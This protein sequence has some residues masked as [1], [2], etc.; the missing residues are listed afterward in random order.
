MNKNLQSLLLICAAVLLFGACQKDEPA[1]AVSIRATIADAYTP[2][3][4]GAKVVVDNTVMPSFV[5]GDKVWVNGAEFTASVSGSDF[6]LELTDGS[7]DSPYSAVYP[8]DFVTSVSGGFPVNLTLPAEQEYVEQNGKQVINAPMAAFGDGEPQLEFKNVCSLVRVR[9][10]NNLGMGEIT[11]SSITITASDANLSGSATISENEGGFTLLVTSG[12]KSVTLTG[13]TEVVKENKSSKDYYIYIPPV[14]GETL[15]ITVNGSDEYKSLAEWSQVSTNEVSIAKS[16]VGAVSQLLQDCESSYTM[17]FS[18]SADKQIYFSK[19]NLQYQPSTNTWR[20]AEKPWIYFVDN[21]SYGNCMTQNA[22]A[23]TDKWIDLFAWGTSGWSGGVN[24]SPYH[25]PYCRIVTGT[26][27]TTTGYGY[28]PTYNS[29]QQSLVGDYANSDWGV[30]NSIWNGSNLDAAGTWRTPTS[31]EWSY[32][33]NRTNRHTI[34]TVN[35][36]K[37]L[38]LLPDHWSKPAELAMTYAATGYTTNVYTEEQWT[39]LEKKGAI[40]LPITGKCINK[41]TSASS[42]YTLTSQTTIG[43]Y[44]STTYYS[45][46]SAKSF[47]FNN[48]GGGGAGSGDGTGYQIKCAR[49]AVRLVKDVQ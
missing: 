9:V 32:L 6:T 38:I 10:R 16:K 42:T 30:Y 1:S 33:Y 47:Y 44:W 22:V 40:F 13:L 12:E 31:S 39:L 2:N 41:I 15:T 26:G 35:S 25:L 14:S 28:G 43:Y 24:A 17:A 46:S 48:T 5:T 4:S 19:G 36:V 11:L 34:A 27:A 7:T 37:G 20:F 23:T 8:K 45:Q 21:S 18:V 49:I 3:Q 29:C